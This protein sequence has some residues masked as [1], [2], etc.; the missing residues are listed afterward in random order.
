MTTG[1]DVR[2]PKFLNSE[3][4]MRNAELEYSE[5]RIAGC[6]LFTTQP[7]TRNAEQTPETSK[8]EIDQQEFNFISNSL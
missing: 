4:G 7:L 5:Y 6:L 2:G 3:C 1:I 8:L